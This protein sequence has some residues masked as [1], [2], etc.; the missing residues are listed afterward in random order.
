MS[1]AQAA[2]SH[3]FTC[4]HAGVKW[5]ER[6]WG[7]WQG[8]KTYTHKLC[9]DPCLPGCVSSSAEAEQCAEIWTSPPK[10]HRHHRLHPKSRTLI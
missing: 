6:W 1:D 2:R 8:L 7:V 3:A 10:I 9:K 4:R 5:M